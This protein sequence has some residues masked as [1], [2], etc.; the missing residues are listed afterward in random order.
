[1]PQLLYLNKTECAVLATALNAAKPS[2]YPEHQRVLVTKIA[3][4]LANFLIDG[5]TATDETVE[6]RKKKLIGFAK[7]RAEDEEL[8]Q[9]CAD[10][11]ESVAITLR[12]ESKLT[13]WDKNLTT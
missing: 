3:R 13:S 9:M 12:G 2:S 5:Q 6:P 8:K 10:M 4:R 1:M 11:N 7:A